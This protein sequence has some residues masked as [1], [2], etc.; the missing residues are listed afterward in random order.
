MKHVYIFL[1]CTSNKKLDFWSLRMQEFYCSF[2]REKQSS[3]SHF[4][5]FIHPFLSHC[6]VA[7]LTMM[8]SICCTCTPDGTEKLFGVDTLSYCF[9]VDTVIPRIKQI[10]RFGVGEECPPWGWHWQFCYTFLFLTMTWSFM[11]QSCKSYG[12]ISQS[13]DFSGTDQWDSYF[14]C[15]LVLSQSWCNFRQFLYFWNCSGNTLEN[16]RVVSRH[17]SSLPCCCSPI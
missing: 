17:G 10:V 16:L 3:L 7:K 8:C 9:G 12:E 4:E 11:Y 15:S 5:I 13:G 6:W 1:S 2:A 14:Q